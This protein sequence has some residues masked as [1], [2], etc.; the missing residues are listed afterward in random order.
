MNY[1]NYTSGQKVLAN[2]L[3]RKVENCGCTIDECVQVLSVMTGA[4]LAYM[5]PSDA[6]IAESQKGGAK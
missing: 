5:A 3:A 6:L 4:L 2:A 1:E